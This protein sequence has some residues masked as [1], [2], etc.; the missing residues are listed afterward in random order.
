MSIPDDEP[1]S[2]KLS[3]CFA[4]NCDDLDSSLL[5]SE[6][7]AVAALGTGQTILFLSPFSYEIVFLSLW[8]E[9]HLCT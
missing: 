9:G 7:D 8:A 5:G 3:L 6:I 1:I 2:D 4:V